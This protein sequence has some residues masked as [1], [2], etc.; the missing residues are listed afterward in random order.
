MTGFLAPVGDIDAMA[1]YCLQLLEDCG[2]ARRYAA[3]ARAQARRF[4]YA[5]IIPQYEK[6]YEQVLNGS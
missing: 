3:A 5:A 4:D 6:I 2:K 1:G